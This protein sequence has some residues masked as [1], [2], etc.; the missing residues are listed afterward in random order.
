M[1]IANKWLHDIESRGKVAFNTNCIKTHAEA[2]KYARAKYMSV[3]ERD[4]FV[5]GW[6]M[7]FW[8][9]QK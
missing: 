4:I 8:S 6:N 5:A 2:E 1:Q 9:E 7:A 3:L